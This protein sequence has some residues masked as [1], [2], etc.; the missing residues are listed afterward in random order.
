MSMQNAHNAEPIRSRG[1]GP[2]FLLSPTVAAEIL[3]EGAS[4]RQALERELRRIETGRPM[5]PTDGTGPMA[6]VR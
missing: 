6:P 4:Y 2:G 5:A 3:A 1:D